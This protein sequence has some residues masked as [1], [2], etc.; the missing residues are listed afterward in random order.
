MNSLTVYSTTWCGSCHR[1]MRQLDREG[2][3][4]DSID[5]ERDPAAAHFV[6]GVNG[7]K[8]TVPT[9]VFSDG[10]ALTN[11]SVKDLLVRLRP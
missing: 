5:I 11:L 3:E 1:V 8:R 4:Y 7:G 9:V 2:V 6:M 10:A